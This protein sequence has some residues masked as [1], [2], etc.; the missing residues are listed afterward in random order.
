MGL[1]QEPAEVCVARGC[2][3][4]QRHVGAPGQGIDASGI[5]RGLHDPTRQSRK[6]E[7]ERHLGAR[8]RLDAFRP[9][10]V[11]ELHGAV[12]AVVVGQGEGGIAQLLCPED[13]LFGVG[14]A[15]QEGKPRVGVELDVGRSGHRMMS[16]GFYSVKESEDN[17]KIWGV[18]EVE[19]LL[20]S[21][22]FGQLLT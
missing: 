6:I 1:T 20:A 4:Q 11:S 9:G 2:L 17:P 3:G 5:V 22:A 12:E 19:A 16:F 14:C 10:P 15:V 7:L 21:A 8:D 13:Q 18:P